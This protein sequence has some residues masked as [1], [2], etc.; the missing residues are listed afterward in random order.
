MLSRLNKRL[1]NRLRQSI[2]LVFLLPQWLPAYTQ[3]VSSFPPSDSIHHRFADNSNLSPTGLVNLQLTQAALE[4]GIW[5]KEYLDKHP[6]IKR[7]LIEFEQDK[8]CQEL[9]WIDNA[10]LTHTELSLLAS[11]SGLKRIVKP[12]YAK[13]GE[14]PLRYLKKNGETTLDT[15]EKGLVYQEIWYNAEGC[16]LRIK[17]DG[18]PNA[19]RPIPHSTKAVLINMAADPGSNENEAFKVTSTGQAVP[20]GPTQD[21]GL[22]SCPYQGHKEY[23]CAEWVDAIMGSSHPTLKNPI[24]TPD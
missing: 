7:K 9:K 23:Y 16:V 18:F 20:K 24:P 12:M 6:L 3:C 5:S 8:L 21:S 11:A 22:A 13:A 14:V 15:Q 17:N 1:W 10:H 4:N 2:L 19:R